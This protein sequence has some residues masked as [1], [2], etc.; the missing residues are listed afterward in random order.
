MGGKAELE[1]AAPQEGA[2][3]GDGTRRGGELQAPQ[4]Q[5]KGGGWA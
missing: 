1:E 5:G 4:G 2:S 3:R